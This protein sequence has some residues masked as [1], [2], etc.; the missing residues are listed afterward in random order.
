MP[1]PSSESHKSCIPSL[2]LINK[3]ENIYNAMHLVNKVIVKYA[4]Y[5]TKFGVR[6]GQLLLAF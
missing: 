6:L 4:I 1:N 5:C 3:T 2:K